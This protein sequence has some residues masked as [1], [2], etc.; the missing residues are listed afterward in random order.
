MAAR[1]GELD[2]PTLVILRLN[3]VSKECKAVE[4]E[5]DYLLFQQRNIEQIGKRLHDFNQ[6]FLDAYERAEKMGY[7]ERRA[8][9]RQFAVQVTLWKKDHKPRYVIDWAFDMG[10]A[11]WQPDDRE[12]WVTWTKESATPSRNDLLYSS[13]A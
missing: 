7:D 1:L 11:W 9:L 12:V 10:D 8:V 3:T 4:A 5:R 13:S 2:D 6:R